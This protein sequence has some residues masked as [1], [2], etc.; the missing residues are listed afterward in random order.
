MNLMIHYFSDDAS[1][2]GNVGMLI[3]PVL[4]KKDYPS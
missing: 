1:F 4:Y 3:Y 2:K